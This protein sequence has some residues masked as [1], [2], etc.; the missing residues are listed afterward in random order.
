MDIAEYL[1]ILRGRWVIV[2]AAVA[3]ALGA[4]WLTSTVAPIGTTTPT[5]T[6][7]T[8]LVSTATPGTL[9]LSTVAA[10]TRIEP[11]ARRAADDLDFQGD[12]STLVANV[13]A[14]ADTDAGTLSVRATAA[15]PQAAERLADAFASAL[16][17]Y[18]NDRTA[19]STT[20]QLGALTSQLDLLDEQIAELD[21]QIASSSG[22]TQA[23]LTAE[24]NAKIVSYGVLSQQYQNLLSSRQ[25]PLGLDIVQNAK[26]RRTTVGGLQAPQ[27]RTS[28][29]IVG[30]LLGLL[31]GVGLALLVER[32]HPKIRTRT[33]AA[34]HYDAPV[35][36]E[37]PRVPRRE[38][39]PLVTASQPRSPTANAFRLLMAGLTRRPGR[40]V[41][42]TRGQAKAI[43]VTSPGPGEGKTTVVAN[44]AV[45]FAETGRSVLMLSCDFTKPRLH[46][47]FGV[48]N[49]PGLSDGLAQ[50]NGEPIFSDCLQETNVQDVMVVASGNRPDN[51]GELLSSGSMRAAIREARRLADVVLFD[52]A[53]LLAQA[54]AAHLL[55][56]VD[57]V[58]VVLR[59]GHTTVD[60]AERGS[61]V[62]QRLGAPVAGVVLNEATGSNMP[63]YYVQPEKGYEDRSR[64][65][66]PAKPTDEA[67]D[68]MGDNPD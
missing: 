47:M 63:R 15:T 66:T 38:R 22:S 29:L 25:S 12:P 65:D 13:F 53:P 39:D 9:N 62:L 44:L 18:L 49:V 21:Q 20:A 27:S 60:L 57:A 6:A 52:T 64:A 3:V 37:I 4:A 58:L 24:R 42:R 14:T 23:L 68:T 55:S 40:D 31:F 2:A 36:A 67:K 5:Y 7:T 8:L 45:A 16:V 33:A 28:R 26:A 17:D 59:E 30:A 35:I 48:P 46:T 51:P 43:L 19:E 32:M 34:K 56:D 50:M 11:V 61:D 54:D 41:P 1:R 10:L